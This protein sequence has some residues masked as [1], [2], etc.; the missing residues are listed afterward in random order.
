MNNIR[1]Y[2]RASAI[3]QD[4]SRAKQQVTD[5]AKANGREDEPR[6]YIENVSGAT[7]QRPKLMLLIDEAHKG[8]ILLIEQIDR[9]TRL[10]EAD[11]ETLKAAIKAKGIVVV[12]IDLPT[13]YGAM[14]DINV[15]PLTDAEAFAQSMLKA[16]NA[17]LMDMLSATA[18]KDYVD[19]RA[20]QKQGI[21]NNK[22]KFK[23]KQPDLERHEV[24]RTL[25][26]A[27]TSYTKIQAT[28]GASRATIAK[29]VKASKDMAA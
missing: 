25:L 4:A 18:R 7:L 14:K 29:I 13:S 28:V 17:M 10:N 19:R 11:W 16:I 15:V 1:I 27:G 26:A 9:L 20:R 5:F 8:D 3:D 6:Y 21:A 22:D 2:L 24:I 12:S 23:G